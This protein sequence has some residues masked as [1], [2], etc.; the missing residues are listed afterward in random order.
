[1]SANNAWLFP[2]HRTPHLFKLV[3]MSST[4]LT[5]SHNQ[6]Q[7]SPSCGRWLKNQRKKIHQTFGDGVF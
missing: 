1:M 5:F 6:T 4:N 3:Q 7:K 2:H